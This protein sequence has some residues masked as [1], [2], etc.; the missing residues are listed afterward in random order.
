MRKQPQFH[1]R[2][3]A[4]WRKWLQ[5][6]HRRSEVIYLVFY[7]KAMGRPGVTY[8]EAVREALCFGWIDGVKKPATRARRAA[9]AV[10]MLLAGKRG[11]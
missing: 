3:R 1:A 6:N 9:K 2:S 11:L 5:A 7:R 8:D 10:E 4:A